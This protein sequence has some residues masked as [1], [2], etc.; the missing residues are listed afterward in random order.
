MSDIYG[1]YIMI[2]IITLVFI[3]YIIGML[4][5]INKVNDNIKRI[6]KRW[7][8]FQDTVNSYQMKTNKR[9]DVL[10]QYIRE[11]ERLKKSPKVTKDDD[12]E[13]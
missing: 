10:E 4:R 12:N 9:L 1:I 6:Y 5:E 13:N 2:S 11:V 3:I 8:E 7:G